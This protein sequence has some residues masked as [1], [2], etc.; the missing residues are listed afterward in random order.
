LQWKR[1]KERQKDQRKCSHMHCV[2]QKPHLCTTYANESFLDIPL[3]TS[4]VRKVGIRRVNR[5]TDDCLSLIVRQ[6]SALAAV[7]EAWKRSH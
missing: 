7:G 5:G 4:L 2:P 6:P 1:D 3:P